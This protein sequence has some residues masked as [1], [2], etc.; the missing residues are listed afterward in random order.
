MPSLGY[1][2]I[3]TSTLEVGIKTAKARFNAMIYTTTEAY[4]PITEGYAKV[5]AP[6]TD[7][8]GNAR[9]LLHATV[10][11]DRHLHRI[12]LSHGVPYGIWLEVRQQG[13]YAVIMPTIKAVGE[14]LMNRFENALHRM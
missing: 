6:W 4:G 12:T 1:L 11:H 5:T 7:R 14:D 13:K 3:N 8:T 10:D 2:K 9:N